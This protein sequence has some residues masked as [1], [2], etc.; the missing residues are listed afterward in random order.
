[1]KVA[2][3]LY[4]A[5][6]VGVNLPNFNQLEAHLWSMQNENGSITTLATG[7]G[8]PSGS[9]NAE[10]TA[11]TLLV[12]NQALISRLHEQHTSKLPEAPATLLIFTL[13]ALMAAVQGMRKK[14]I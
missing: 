12:Y 13:F 4:G 9:A 10:T 3:L 7:H 1:M 5:Q 6:V 8:Q 2:L 14:K 11:I